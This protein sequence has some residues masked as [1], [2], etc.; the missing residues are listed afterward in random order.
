MLYSVEIL[1]RKGF[2]RAVVATGTL[3][4][5]INMPCKT[6]VFM[7]DS[8]FHTALNYRQASGR[9]GRRGFD[10][11]GNVVF[12]DIKP[13]RVFDI[14]SSK[15][16][17]MRGQFALSTTLVLRVLGLLHE[18]EDNPYA[19]NIAKTLLTQ[20]RLFLGGPESKMFVQHHLRF[21]IE[22]LRRQ[23]LLSRE[24]A[25][26]N[27]AGLVG[28]LYFTENAAFAF[29]ALLKE[30]YLHR[31]CANISSKGNEVLDEL[32]LVMAHLFSRV[33]CTNTVIMSVKAGAVLPSVLLPNLPTEAEEISREH[34]KH[35]LDIFTS[36]ATTFARM[37]LK[38]VPDRVLPY[39]QHSVGPEQSGQHGSLD[40]LPPCFLRSP[41]AGLSGHDDTF[42]STRDL[43]SNVRSGVFMEESAIPS[44][45]ISPHDTGGPLN[46]YLFNFYKH[47]DLRALSKDNNIHKGSVYNMLRDFTMILSTIVASLKHYTNTDSVADDEDIMGTYDDENDSDDEGGDAEAGGS[48]S[49]SS[50]SGGSALYWANADHGTLEQVQKAFAMLLEEFD[51]KL[52]KHAS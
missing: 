44:L 7:G 17:D 3:A 4:L 45:S 31:L 28:H 15:L 38:D 24:G 39:T 52:W 42:S 6:V 20:N 34:H 41:F 32:A 22:Y 2:L 46:A 51:G 49:V 10:L 18:T 14:M 5:G 25:P 48:G 35:I 29:H 1:F 9:A 16:P 37:H 19:V 33:Y 11:L 23:H 50:S 30:G 47:G 21:S 40:K 27:F 13:Q 8:I 26:I 43:C 36:Y 12:A